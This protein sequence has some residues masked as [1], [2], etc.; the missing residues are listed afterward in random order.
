MEAIAQR[1]EP[2][3]GLASSPYIEGTMIAPLAECIPGEIT[4]DE[5]FQRGVDEYGAIV[6]VT[7]GTSTDQGAQMLLRE[8]RSPAG[9]KSVK[10]AL[11]LDPATEERDLTLGGVV[12]TFDVTKVGR[13]RSFRRPDGSVVLGCDFECVYRG[14]GDEDAA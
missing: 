10:R 14:D 12:Q 5:T 6:R 2:I 1:L 9:P 8:F 11:E 4:F 13:M 3:D 7:V